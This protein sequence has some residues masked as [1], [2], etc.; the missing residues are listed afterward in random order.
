MTTMTTDDT[1]R[2][3]YDLATWRRLGSEDAAEDAARGH[4]EPLQRD[5][6]VDVLAVHHVGDLDRC[7][8]DEA[9]SDAL[10]A[11]VEGYLHGG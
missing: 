2:T 3:F 4:V 11:L 9:R 8:D 1:P 7:A 10:D 6:L 5:D